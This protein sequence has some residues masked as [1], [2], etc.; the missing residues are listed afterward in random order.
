M[1]CILARIIVAIPAV[2]TILASSQVRFFIL[3]ILLA[4]LSRDRTT[5]PAPLVHLKE[6]E[7]ADRTGNAASAPT[8]TTAT[9]R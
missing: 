4:V 6:T 9:A 3:L 7:S 2:P 5:T 8:R 1:K